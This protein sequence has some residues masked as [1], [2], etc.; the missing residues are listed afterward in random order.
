MYKNWSIG[1]VIVALLGTFLILVSM[2]S[3]PQFVLMHH[4][5]VLTQGIVAP[6]IIMG[7]IVWAIVEFFTPPGRTISD[8]LIRIIPAFIVGGFIGG[9]LGYMF[10]RRPVRVRA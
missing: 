3:R 8:L 6:A 4:T 5:I 2:L 10:N 7:S 1:A 9:L